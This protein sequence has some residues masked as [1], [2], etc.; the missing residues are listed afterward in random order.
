MLDSVL[1]LMEQE[2][3]S[4]VVACDDGAVAVVAGAQGK[5]DPNLPL[6]ASRARYCWYCWWQ[7]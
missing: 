2:L 4:A 6:K 5:V 3:R 1:D 7:Y